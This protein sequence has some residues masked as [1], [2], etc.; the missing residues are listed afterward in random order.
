MIPRR[1]LLRVGGTTASAILSGLVAGCASDG[2][3]PDDEPTT[4]DGETPTPTAEPSTTTAAEPDNG[5][6]ALSTAQERLGALARHLRDAAVDDDTEFEDIDARQQLHDVNTALDTAEEAVE[7]TDGEAQLTTLQT[8]RDVLERIIEASETGIENG[9]GPFSAALEAHGRTE[10]HEVEPQV[11][12][13]GDVLNSDET[14]E[15]SCGMVGELSTA[16]AHFDD[17]IEGFDQTTDILEQADETFDEIESAVTEFEEIDADIVRAAI[18][19]GRS[20]AAAMS[21]LSL[22]VKQSSNAE[23]ASHKAGLMWNVGWNPGILEGDDCPVSFDIQAVPHAETDTDE[24][25]SYLENEIRPTY[26]EAKQLYE[27]ATATL[28][29]INSEALGPD[30]HPVREVFAC[31][32][33]F[34]ADA[35]DHRIQAIDGRLE[36]WR[37][38]GLE[39]VNNDRGEGEET[40]TEHTLQAFEIE[41][42]AAEKC[43]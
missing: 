22:G 20:F 39:G 4:T 34:T 35:T 30:I 3:S 37:E 33:D 28:G 8:L 9:L 36:T 12:A 40:Y 1:E 27:D 29:E 14:A 25:P 26:V 18:D 31:H 16:V 23:I 2:G 21:T 5:S 42:E 19:G 6:E 11:N 41:G 7:T 10:E 13:D 24:W 43:G 17:A 38:Y 32:A 15:M